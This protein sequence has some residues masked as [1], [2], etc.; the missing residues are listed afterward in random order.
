MAGVVTLEEASASNHLDLSAAQSAT[1]T[2]SALGIRDLSSASS[3]PPPSPSRNSR[4]PSSAAQPDVETHNLTLF[5]R[6][7]QPWSSGAVGLGLWAAGGV[8]S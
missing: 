4:R 1:C 8:V 3:D 6:L 5:H 7:W 2:R